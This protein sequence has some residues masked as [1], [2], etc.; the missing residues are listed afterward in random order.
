MS[1]LN[2]LKKNKL[3]A[4][5][6]GLLIFVSL[7]PGCL[8]FTNNL[9]QINSKADDKVAIATENNLNNSSSPLG[10]GLSEITDWST[11]LPFLDA[12]RSARVWQTEPQ[13][14][15]L[16]LDQNG[17][18]KSI[19]PGTKVITMV[20]REIP[21][22]YPAGR[23]VA[24]YDGEGTINYTFDAK[25]IES[26]SRL[27]R[28][29]L[30]VKPEGGGIWM[31]I[32]A[33][34]PKH[35]GNYLRNIRI[36][37]EQYEKTFKTQIF[38]PVFLEKVKSFRTLRFMDWIRTNNSPQKEWE[39]RSKLTDYTWATNKGA[40]VEIMVEL[41][42]RVKVNPWFNMP[43]MATDDYITKFAQYVKNHLDPSLTAYIEY[44]NEVWNW[45]FEQSKYASI[46]G[47][48]RWGENVG[49]AWL[50]WSGMKSAQI[51]DIWKKQ[52]F[53]GQE[54]RVFCTISSQSGWKG[55]E[56][57]V[58]NC[59]NW[60]A[61]GNEPCWK[62]GIGGYAITGYFS[63]Q[64]G[65]PQNVEK[66]LS[67]RKDPDGGF[68]KV[69]QQL[70]EGKLL[71]YGDSVPDI[72]DSFRY[73]YKVAQD[74]GL[75]LITYEGGSHIVGGGGAENN[76]EL[77]DFLIAVNKRPEMYD[78]YTQLLK[79]WKQNRGTLFSHHVDIS[80]SS[81]WGSWGALEYVNQ[82]G[83]PKYNA[84]RDFI[85]KNPCWWDGCTKN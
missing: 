13:G 9:S 51:C 52:V 82:N 53:V 72:I 31:E 5:T 2:L 73:F 10:I 14:Q 67:W 71:G 39:Q 83:S 57:S 55:S 24:L 66:V 11:E 23:Y 69:F 38:N 81:K 34:D 8:S 79:G 25:K 77:T 47:K 49:D 30:E 3:L 7:I 54:N 45:S 21:N 35:T 65:Q 29:V 58:F 64:L 12:F 43:H 26:E 48:A 1:P 63:G 70:R 17:W 56:D 22:M 18:I 84:L 62:H 15:P 59:K 46:Q 75:R 85:D 33:T 32:T 20:L 36:I 50:Q 6:V 27:G 74:K 16:E 28:D 19:P 37:Q 61:E 40:P 42:N 60:V 4:F 68:G 44:S 41:A 78:I 80:R 76:Q